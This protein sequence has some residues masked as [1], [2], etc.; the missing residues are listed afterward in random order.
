MSIKATFTMA[1]WWA[2]L[3]RGPRGPRGESSREGGARLEA[4]APPTKLC[5]PFPTLEVAERTSF[6]PAFVGVRYE[7]RIGP[8]CGSRLNALSGKR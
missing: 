2:L 6:V 7:A 4:W 3:L 5:L 8:V 1:G